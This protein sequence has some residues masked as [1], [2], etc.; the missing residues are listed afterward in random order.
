M[1]QLVVVAHVWTPGGLVISLEFHATP[2]SRSGLVL[3]WCEWWAAACFSEGFFSLLEASIDVCNLQKLS[4]ESVLRGSIRW[5]YV[6]IRNLF[7]G[8]LKCAG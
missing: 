2:T 7:S 8:L 4:A 5:H 1:L 3:G 6:N